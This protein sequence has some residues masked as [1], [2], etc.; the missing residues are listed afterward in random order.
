MFRN[1]RKNK[2]TLLD[3]PAP[4]NTINKKNRHA[5]LSFQELNQAHSDVK[6]IVSNQKLTSFEEKI[7]MAIQEVLVQIKNLDI[8]S[9]DLPTDEEESAAVVYATQ[10]EVQKI[11]EGEDAENSEEEEEKH[12]VS[13]SILDKILMA[14]KK[15][16]FYKGGNC[17]EKAFVGFDLLIKHFIKKNLSTITSA[18]PLS[19]EYFKDHFIVLVN[20]RFVVDPWL[21]FAFAYEKD[22]TEIYKVFEFEHSQLNSYFSIG[23]N[24]YCQEAIAIRENGRLK[25]DEMSTTSTYNLFQTLSENREIQSSES[26]LFASSLTMFSPP[27]LQNVYEGNAIYAYPIKDN[28][29]ETFM[30]SPKAAIQNGDKSESG[31]DYGAIK[32]D[33]RNRNSYSPY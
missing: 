11:L 27:D 8:V 26:S 12:I 10:Q 18:I 25:Y 3:Y 24:W 32:E 5:L 30:I 17:Q 14:S 2:N 29:E 20:D 31:Y 13:Q 4:R 33:R 23:P 7:W 28:N 9:C 21:S 16:Q 19:L 22:R 1:I 15:I 6:K